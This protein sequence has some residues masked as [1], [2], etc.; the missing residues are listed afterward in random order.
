MPTRSETYVTAVFYLN[1][2]CLGRQGGLKSDKGAI[3]R[4]QFRL[5]I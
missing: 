1:I 4:E 2:R 3:I 5:K